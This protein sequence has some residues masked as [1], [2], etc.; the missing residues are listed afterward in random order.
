[1]NKSKANKKEN[2]NYTS[3]KDNEWQHIFFAAMCCNTYPSYALKNFRGLE[4]KQN[5]IYIWPTLEIHKIPNRKY[6]WMEKGTINQL[7]I[8]GKLYNI[9]NF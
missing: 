3:T 4:G 5:V 1:M 7:K 2:I 6:V 8:N 9:L